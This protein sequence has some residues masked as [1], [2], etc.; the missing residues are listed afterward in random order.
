MPHDSITCMICCSSDSSLKKGVGI[1]FHGL[2]STSFFC[3]AVFFLNVF[4][5]FFCFQKHI[6]NIKDL[7]FK[8]SSD[9]G[10]I[11]ETQLHYDKMIECRSESFHY[12]FDNF[13]F[14]VKKCLLP[15][16]C[17]FSRSRLLKMFTFEFYGLLM[18]H[19]LIFKR[20]RESNM[21]QWY[22]Y[23]KKW[24]ELGNYYFI[25]VN[26][27]FPNST[28]KFSKII[29]LFLDHSH[30]YEFPWFPVDK[31]NGSSWWVVIL[32]DSIVLE[33][34]LWKVDHTRSL[35]EGNTN[36]RRVRVVERTGTPE[37]DRWFGF[38]QRQTASPAVWEK[39]HKWWWKRREWNNIRGLRRRDKEKLYT[40]LWKP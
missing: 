9:S 40:I 6:I 19:I 15:S 33:I 18:F 30:T 17:H 21:R 34:V 8:R 27:H 14:T 1:L 10:E 28:F 20:C 13:L 24:Q 23:L 25:T 7:E 2:T 12:F 35:T 31:S 11:V 32:E 38:F 4:F 16:F 22:S 26:K 39:H 5:W 3:L 36:K 37:Y 29:T